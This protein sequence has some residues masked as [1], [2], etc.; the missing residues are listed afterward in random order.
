M[1]LPSLSAVPA[2]GRTVPNGYRGG[3]QGMSP[4][5][6]HIWALRKYNINVQ[7]SQLGY[8]FSNLISTNIC[9]EPVK[10]ERPRYTKQ[11]NTV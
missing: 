4:Q 9:F 5:C 7:R 10:R 2:H 11:S 8:Q 6:L 1:V 3:Q